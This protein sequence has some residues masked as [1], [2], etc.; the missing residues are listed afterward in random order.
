MPRRFENPILVPT[1]VIDGLE[2]VRESGETNMQDSMKVKAIATRLGYPEV[3][4]WIDKHPHE[5]QEG[6][7]RGFVVEK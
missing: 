4:V 2:T 3:K 5:Y 7:F 6:I 1:P